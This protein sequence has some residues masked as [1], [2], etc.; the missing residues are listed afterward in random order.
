MGAN[1]KFLDSE[2]ARSNRRVAANFPSR[3]VVPQILQASFS[4]V[5]PMQLEGRRFIV[6]RMICKIK[7]GC[8]CISPKFVG[9]MSD[10]RFE[11]S[12]IHHLSHGLFYK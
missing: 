10:A 1:I 5:T 3:V 11:S 9:N 2:T 7:C 12:A 6:T 4:S 8:I